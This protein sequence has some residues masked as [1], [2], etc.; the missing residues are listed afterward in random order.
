MWGA[1]W[2]IPTL[3]A[4]CEKAKA[5]GVELRTEHKHG[6]EPEI[7]AAR[8]QEVKKQFADSAVKLIGMGTNQAFHDPD[9]KA[10]R[11]SIERAKEFIKLSH[12]I[13]GSGTKVKPNDLPKNVPQEK[14]IEQIGKSL[15]ELGK[16]AA[17][18]GQQVRLEVHGQCQPL[19]IIAQIMKVADNPNVAVCWNSNDKDLGGDGLEHNFNLVKSRLGETLHSRDLDGKKYPY[20]KLFKLLKEAKYHGWILIEASDHPPDIVAA[21]AHQHEVFERLA[22][23]GA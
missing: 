20:A 9:P 4:N 16:F 13:G 18:Y 5:A 23:D 11:A 21:L 8:R 17:D 2:D 19:P 22:A 3:I 10:L 6:V 14:T 12:D 1:E 7:S 15:N